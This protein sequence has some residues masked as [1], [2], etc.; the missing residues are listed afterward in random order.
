MVYRFVISLLISLGFCSAATSAYVQTSPT[1]TAFDVVSTNWAAGDDVSLQVPIGFTFN[2]NGTNY[3]SVFMG[4]NGIL[5]FTAGT[6][7]YVNTVLTDASTSPADL[8]A[9]YWEDLYVPGGGTITYG[10]IGAAPNRKFVVSWNAV[11]VY[12]AATITCT[13]QV[14]LG[15]DQSIRFRYSASSVGCNGA[16]GA[17]SNGATIGVRE[18][19]SSMSQYSYNTAFTAPLE[20]L[21]NRTSVINFQKTATL[22]CDPINGVTNPKSIPGA[23]TRWTLT[24][25]NSGS[26]SATLGPVLDALSANTTFDPN[27]VAGASAAACKSASPGVPQS[28]TGRGFQISLTGGTRTGFPKFLT[29]SS[30]ADGATFTGPS[31]VSLD[32]STALPAATGYTAGELKAGEAVTI[33]FN[34]VVN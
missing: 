5:T 7:T 2:F 10:T 6:S 18:S 28:A 31:T 21:Y 30:D 26:A 24:V 13:F 20:L 34:T 8:I 27:L 22:I 3:T 29:S 14:V 9:P 19:L 12:S 16:G 1:P 25:R 17:G 32:F 15:E 4:S 11:Q 33:Y 23:I